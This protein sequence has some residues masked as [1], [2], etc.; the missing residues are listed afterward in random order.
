MVHAGQEKEVIIFSAVRANE[1]GRVGFLADRRRLNVALTR[2]RRGL[3]V[4]GCQKTLSHDPTWRQVLPAGF[5]FK[6]FAHVSVTWSVWSQVLYAVYAVF[7]L[8]V[9]VT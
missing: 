7:A 5:E 6:V 1:Q 2:S 4:I 9:T 3:I 8:T